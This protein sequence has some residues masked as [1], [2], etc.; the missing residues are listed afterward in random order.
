[1]IKE[2]NAEEKMKKEYERP[3]LKILFLEDT[4]V[5][6]TDPYEFDVDWGYNIFE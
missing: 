5:T 6:S 4:I 1:M 3:V 2:K